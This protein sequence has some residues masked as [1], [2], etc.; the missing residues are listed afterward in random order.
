MKFAEYRSEWLN[1]LKQQEEML[2]VEKMSAEDA[3]ALGVIMTGL[4]KEKYKQPI[5][6]RII[7]GGH[8][9]FSFLMD[10][11]SR[12]NEWWMDKKLNT[13][14]LSG[15]SSIRT[16]VEVAEGIRP[17]EMEYEQDGDYALCG[18]CFP[19]R[20]GEGRLL[21]YVLASGMPHEC[22]HQLIAD[23]LAEFLNITV[24]SLLENGA[25]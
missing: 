18:G 22:D 14:R 16:L 12:H 6:I 17:M 5:A 15:V 3:L 1:V 9:A 4:A 20:N 24:P 10:G 11:T 25:E 8:I 21:G 7:L 13:C 2:R 23:A 19:L